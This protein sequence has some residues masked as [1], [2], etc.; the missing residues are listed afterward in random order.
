M[1]MKRYYAR[2]DYIVKLK[3]SIPELF[4]TLIPKKGKVEIGKKNDNLFIIIDGEIL[5]FEYNGEYIPTLKAIMKLGI[6]I[7]KKYVTVDRGA[8]PHITSGADIMRPGVV[9]YDKRIKKGE[10][11][12]VKEENYG[13]PIA[14]GKALWNGEEFENKKKGKCVKNLHYVG[15]KIWKL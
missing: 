10:I 13:K 3:K 2:K 15:D 1:P 7:D 6:E 9:D 14:I 12:I 4:Q 5:F 8:I 11:V